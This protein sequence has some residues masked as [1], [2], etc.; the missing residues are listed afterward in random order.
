MTGDLSGYNQ[1]VRVTRRRKRQREKANSPVVRVVQLE[2]PLERLSDCRTVP[3]LR[4]FLVRNE[5][6]VGSNPISSTK[7]QRSLKNRGID[8]SSAAAISR[9]EFV[10]ARTSP[11]SRNFLQPDWLV[12]PNSHLRVRRFSGIGSAHLRVQELSDINITA[13]VWKHC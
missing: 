5:E 10:V 12:S 6:V 1:F 9:Y 2:S 13:S 3:Y 11:G 8:R 4:F 7:S